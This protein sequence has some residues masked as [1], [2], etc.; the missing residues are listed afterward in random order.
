MLPIEPNKLC[1]VIQRKRD[2]LQYTSVTSPLSKK[3]TS[4]SEHGFFPLIK[5][6][7][8]GHSPLPITK[9]YVTI[10]PC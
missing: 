9:G 7:S 1:C 8:F 5:D 2:V 3:N 4:M 6:H 10:M